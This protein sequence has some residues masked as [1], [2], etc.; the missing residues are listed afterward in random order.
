LNVGIQT[1]E[2]AK[3]YESLSKSYRSHKIGKAL[4]GGSSRDEKGEV[5][6][7][8]VTGPGYKDYTTKRVRNWVTPDGYGR[9]ETYVSK[10]PDWVN[11]MDAYAPVIDNTGVVHYRKL[12]ETIGDANFVHKTGIPIN[13][14]EFEKPVYFTGYNGTVVRA[15]M[16]KMTSEGKVV[17]TVNDKGQMYPALE[18]TNELGS[19][20]EAGIL[21]SKDD[22][23]KKFTLAASKLEKIKTPKTEEEKEEVMKLVEDNIFAFMWARATGSLEN[24]TVYN[25]VHDNTAEFDELSVEMQKEIAEK[26]PKKINGEIYYSM[27]IYVE[28][29][30]SYLLKGDAIHNRGYSNSNTPTIELGNAT[31]KYEI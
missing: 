18:N 12:E 10:N 30:S 27:P 13:S 7:G 28:S 1:L 24:N 22:L 9:A 4:G 8:E 11:R 31:K 20:D 25:L 6:Y 19:Y 23:M 16:I 21:I 15:P 5:W 26:A 29:Q 17:M 3:P 14:H 2:M